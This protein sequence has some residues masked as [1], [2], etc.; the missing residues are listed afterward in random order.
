MHTTLHR[1]VSKDQIE[2]Y[3]FKHLV[4][5]SS[6]AVL[7]QLQANLNDIYS[8]QTLGIH[9]LSSMFLVNIFGIY[10]YIRL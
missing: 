1:Q 10:A 8:D 4:C 5:S 9:V 6:S 3:H 7:F 2:C